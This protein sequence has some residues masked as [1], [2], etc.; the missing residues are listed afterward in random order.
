MFYGHAQKILRH[1][2]A[3]LQQGLKNA[4][5]CDGLTAELYKLFADELTTFLTHVFRESIG[6]EALPL[7][8]MQ[9]IITLIPKPKKDLTNLDN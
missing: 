8:L 3:L 9:G 4:P 5:G 7:T 6:K 2:G 1:D